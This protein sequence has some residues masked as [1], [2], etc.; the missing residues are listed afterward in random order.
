[1]KSQGKLKKTVERPKKIKKTKGSKS[2]I[3]I[4]NEI[5][6]ETKGNQG[7]RKNKQISK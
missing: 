5:I 3:I 6:K 7:Q 4:T 2:K 1:M